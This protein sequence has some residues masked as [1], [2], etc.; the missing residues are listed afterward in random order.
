MGLSCWH[1]NVPVSVCSQHSAKVEAGAFISMWFEIATS[2]AAF[3]KARIAIYG[4]R[5][6]VSSWVIFYPAARATFFST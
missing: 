3:R 5:G 2:L 4:A 1:I 6:G